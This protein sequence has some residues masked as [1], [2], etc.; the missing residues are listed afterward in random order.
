M[1]SKP[2]DKLEKLAGSRVELLRVVL[3]REIKQLEHITRHM[4]DLRSINKEY[5]QSVVGKSE[6]GPQHLAHRREFVEKLRDKLE[7]LN[8]DKTQMVKR[9]DEKSTELKYCSAQHSAIG[10]LNEKRKE[11][12]R[13]SDNQREQKQ[14]DEITGAQHLSRSRQ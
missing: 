9:I 6:I 1:S 12:L 2:L 4:T 3:M 11:S 8:D 5:Q 13:K 14:L 7:A 10:I